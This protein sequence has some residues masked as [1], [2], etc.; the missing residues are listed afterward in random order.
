MSKGIRDNEHYFKISQDNPEK[1]LDEFYIFD[2]KHPGLKKYAENT[3]Q[4]KDILITIKTLTD[5]KEKVAVIEKYYQELQKSLS[6]FSNC[7]EFSCF[8]NACD[9][10]LDAVKNDIELLKDITK[11]YFAKRVL[12]E[13]VPE[14]W[15]QAILDSNSSRKKGK[16]GEIKLGVI[17]GKTGFKKVESWEEFEKTRKCFAEFSSIFSM[18]EIRDRLDVKIKTKKQGKKL[19]LIMKADDK[20]F[21]LRQSI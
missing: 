8:V 9:N 11:R 5:K 7:S 17:L 21:S 14:E 13:L 16:C 1:H 3:R 6:E 18:K 10:T 2:K 20:F 19:D 4:L 15:I 12:N